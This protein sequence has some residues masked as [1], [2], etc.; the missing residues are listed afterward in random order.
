MNGTTAPN[1]LP[2]NHSQPTIS[3]S[4]GGLLT[5]APT[6]M[7]PVTTLNGEHHVLGGRHVCR[8]AK[9]RQFDGICSNTALSMAYIYRDNSTRIIVRSTQRHLRSNALLTP[10]L[11]LNITVMAFVQMSWRLSCRI[12]PAPFSTPLCVF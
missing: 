12:I 9:L 3:T 2:P 11:S 7:S 6:G 1:G 10:L 5:P 8:V 4:T